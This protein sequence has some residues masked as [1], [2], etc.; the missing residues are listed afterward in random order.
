MG[1]VIK[2]PKQVKVDLADAYAGAFVELMTNCFLGGR[3]E[4]KKQPSAIILSFS[5]PKA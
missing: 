3:K 2:F 1:E 4:V 5:R